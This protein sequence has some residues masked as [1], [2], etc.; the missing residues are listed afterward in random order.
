MIELP[1]S[2]SQMSEVTDVEQREKLIEKINRDA[3]DITDR[4]IA[5]VIAPLIVSNVFT[6]VKGQYDAILQGSEFQKEYLEL[7]NYVLSKKIIKDK[8]QD[9]GLRKAYDIA[10]YERN[11]NKKSNP[12][13]ISTANVLT[14]DENSPLM[15]TPLTEV[16]YQK[17]KNY[18][19]YA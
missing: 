6:G 12:E 13:K 8:L 9:E 16:S 17:T 15:Q 19:N 10:L 2:M 5:D 11:C 3:N 4:F 1:D 18:A 14:A 7:A